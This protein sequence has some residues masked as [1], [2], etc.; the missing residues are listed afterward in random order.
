M[1]LQHEQISLRA[2]EPE[3]LDL[4]Y[5]IENNRN[6]WSVGSTTAPYSRYALKQHIA[7]Q[8]QDIYQS[9]EFRLVICTTEGKAVGLIDLFNFDPYNLRA[10]VGIALLEK[11]RGHGY[12]QAALQTIETYARHVLHIRMLYAHISHDNNPDSK[13]LFAKQGY[14]E[15][16][17]LPQWHLFRNKF[18]DI[19]VFCKFLIK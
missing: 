19:S 5:S 13:L 9:G 3:D 17:V 1:I 12:A 10:E 7:M 11:A 6:N 16:A 15:I 18:E 2:L 14:E 4:L 8:P